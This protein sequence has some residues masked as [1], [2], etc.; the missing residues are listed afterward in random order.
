M[1]MYTRTICI[2]STS[3][4]ST[5]P[6]KKECRREERD[7]CSTGC[8]GVQVQVCV[9]GFNLILLYLTMQFWMVIVYGC[10]NSL[11]STTCYVL[12]KKAVKM[13]LQLTQPS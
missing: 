11:H 1:Y 7:I 10:A 13:V 9:V 5:F 4:R 2:C 8:L 12:N 3:R 6:E